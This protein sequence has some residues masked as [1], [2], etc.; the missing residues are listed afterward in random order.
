MTLPL[1][2]GLRVLQERILYA[3]REQTPT[4]PARIQNA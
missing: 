1:G 2:E 3:L 4:G